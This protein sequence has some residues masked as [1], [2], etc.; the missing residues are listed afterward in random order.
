MRTQ[1]LQLETPSSPHSLD[2]R[3]ERVE[4]HR[5]H[6]RWRTEAGIYQAKNDGL[7]WRVT[8]PNGDCIGIETTLPAA[9]RAVEDDLVHPDF[10]RG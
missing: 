2:F 5:N 4:G 7:G 3:C 8:A 9:R 1:R 10:V 6:Y